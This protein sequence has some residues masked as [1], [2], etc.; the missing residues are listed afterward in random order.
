MSSTKL[1]ISKQDLRSYFVQYLSQGDYAKCARIAWPWY[2]QNEWSDKIWK[3]IE[4]HD[5]LCIMGHASASKTFTASIWFL[6]DWLAWAD[7]TALIMTSATMPSMNVRIWADFKTLWT[8]SRIDLSTTAT[9]VDS[10]H[11]IRKSIHE[12]KEAIHAVAAD[13]DDS[14]SKVQGL[15]CKRNRLIIDEADNP[16][17][18]AIWGAI[19]NLSSSGHFKGIALA[20]PDDKNSEFGS[21]C[22]PVNGWDSINPEVDHEWESRLGWHVL[23][24]DA[25]QSPNIIAGKDIHPYLF[26]NANLT[27]AREH[28]FNTRSWWSF[29]RAWYGSDSLITN[30]FSSGIFDNTKKPHI[31]Y[32]TKIPIASCDPAFEGGDDCVLMLGFMGREAHNPLKTVVEVNEY[33]KITRKDMTK[34]ITQDFGDQIKTILVE[35]GVKPEYFAIDSSGNALGIRDHLRTVYGKEIYSV[36]FGGSASDRKL[37][38]EE[39]NPA[40]QRY[41][42]LVTE[43]WYAAREWCRLGLVYLK[44]P[45]RDLRIQLESRR[46]ELRGKDAKTGRELI[47]AE[48]KTEMK[49]RG[50]TSPDYGDAFSLLIHLVRKHALGFTPSGFHEPTRKTVKKFTRYQSIFKQ[51]YESD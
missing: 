16:Y 34:E 26:N 7:D 24:L 39:S 13:G 22:E 4:A 40:N 3:N 49:A 9:I 31:W 23:R 38:A 1:K 5:R 20:N 41:K 12:A 29:V 36:M 47:M 51:T 14:Q 6:L 46:Y 32:S 8:K 44:E 19:T 37:T 33:L 43:L 21:H 50:L 10:K 48:P 28:K 35:R 42:N 2:Q 18:N 30:I 25:L 15:H 27:E 45:P 11:V 17:S